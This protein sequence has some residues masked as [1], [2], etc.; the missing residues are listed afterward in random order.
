MRK[1]LSEKWLSKERGSLKQVSHAIYLFLSI[2]LNMM[3]FVQNDCQM[4]IIVGLLLNFRSVSLI[5]IPDD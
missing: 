2:S 5:D 3:K 4:R 1:L